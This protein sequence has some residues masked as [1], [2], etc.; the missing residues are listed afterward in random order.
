MI[1]HRSQVSE[2]GLI[3]PSVWTTRKEPERLMRSDGRSGPVPPPQVF[4]KQRGTQRIESNYSAYLA[5]FIGI[6]IKI[7]G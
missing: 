5:L 6:K 1:R 7:R 4:K 3:D 2:E